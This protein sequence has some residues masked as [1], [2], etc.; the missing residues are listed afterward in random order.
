MALARS[1]VHA[2]TQKITSYFLGAGPHA[3]ERVERDDGTVTI[4]MFDGKIAGH[5]NT[6]EQTAEHLGEQLRLIAYLVECREGARRDDPDPIDRV[7]RLQ[8]GKRP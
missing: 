1:E 6:A 2:M 7:V 8:R 3:A 4:R 5:G